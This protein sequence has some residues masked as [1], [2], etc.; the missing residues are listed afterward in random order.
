[1]IAAAFM[2]GSIG[3]FS[4]GTASAEH[5]HSMET[6]NGSCVLLAQNGAEKAV[7]LPNADGHPIHVNVHKGAPGRD[8]K[9]GVYDKAGDPCLGTDNYLND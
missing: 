1:M 6:G 8:G 3:L 7:T 5:T 2:V 4:A 9:I